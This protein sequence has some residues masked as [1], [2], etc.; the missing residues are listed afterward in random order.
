MVNRT[1][2]SQ[3]HG[4]GWGNQSQC[5]Q[6][7]KRS[8]YSQNRRVYDWRSRIGVAVGMPCHR[9][10]DAF[11]VFIELVG[12]AYLQLVENSME[13]RHKLEAEKL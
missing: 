11:A 10:G 12:T 4:C 8:Y 9:D 7:R 5:Y 13:F 1:A 2:C 3:H 6:S